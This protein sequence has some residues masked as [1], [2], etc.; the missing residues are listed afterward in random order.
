MNKTKRVVESLIGLLVTVCTL[1]LLSMG[2]LSLLGSLFAIPADQPH[3]PRLEGHT[4]LD[5][6]Q[7]TPDRL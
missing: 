1:L 5:T 2:A 7:F 3:H 6:E 4:D